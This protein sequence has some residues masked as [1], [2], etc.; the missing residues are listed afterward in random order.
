MQD[1]ISE[2]N[3]FLLQHRPVLT[4]YLFM[5]NMHLVE[6]AVFTVFLRH[7][8]VVHPS[9]QS[10]LLLPKSEMVNLCHMHC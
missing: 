8:S 3:L 2:K 9:V 4:R 6:S 5:D 7:Y 10:D 1:G